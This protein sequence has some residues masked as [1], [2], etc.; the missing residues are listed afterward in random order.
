M[1]TIEE[2]EKTHQQ[3]PIIEVKASNFRE[4]RGPEFVIDDSMETF[5]SMP[6]IGDKCNCL[7]DGA[8]FITHIA[9]AFRKGNE[10]QYG[11]RISSNDFLSNKTSEDY[12][13]FDVMD[14]TGKNM[15]I[16]SQ[17]YQAGNAQAGSFSAYG[18]RAYTPKEAKQPKVTQFKTEFEA[19]TDIEG[20][21][22]EPIKIQASSSLEFDPGAEKVIDGN[23]GSAFESQ[24]RGRVLRF[25]FEEQ[26]NITAME[27]VSRLPEAKQQLIRVNSQDLQSLKPDETVRHQFD[28]NISG[29]YVDIILN[30]NT[31]DD[32][33]NLT[34]VR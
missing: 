20:I 12:E 11:F 14:F 34:S 5:F 33:N 31:V 1:I 9:I 10:R 23:E 30:G 7:F 18:I 26:Y 6:N 13:V 22:S 3:V 17:G 25:T 4:G 19:K 8:K 27:F 32:K 15:E 2:L 28:P 16:I 29:N 21:S 24:G